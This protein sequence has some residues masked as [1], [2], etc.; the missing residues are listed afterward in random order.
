MRPR[1]FVAPEPRMKHGEAAAIGRF[2]A[3]M[4]MPLQPWQQDVLDKLEQHDMFQEFA[5]IVEAQE[6]LR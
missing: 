6:W 4:G 2:C 3:R 5:D 1:W